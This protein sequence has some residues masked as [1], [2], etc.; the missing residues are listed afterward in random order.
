MSKIINIDDIEVHVEYKKIRN[1]YIRILP[2]DGQ[3]NM[4][5]P[6]G[7]SEEA[8]ANFLISKKAWIK[9]HLSEIKKKEKNHILYQDGD[10]ISIWGMPYTL[11]VTEI[12]G[13][14]EV[15]IHFD[16]IYM[17]V[18]KNS[19]YE[20]RKKL[21]DNL[22]R[23]QLEAELSK[24]FARCIPIVGK[25]PNEWHIKNMKTRWGTCN[26]VDKR[27]WINLQLAKYPVRCLDYVVIHEL[28]HLHERGH[29][30]RFWAL[31]DVFCPEWRQ[32]R[33]ELSQ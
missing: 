24:S 25:Q 33:K 16:K 14:P 2:P 4:S 21:I 30:K 29:T 8:A 11:K 13:R 1:I 27:I 12:T 26:V 32:I 23:E 22:Y 18:K 7:M 15:I 9:E 28:T 5:V 17:R 19:T 10:K 20:E 31:M 3:V 6:I